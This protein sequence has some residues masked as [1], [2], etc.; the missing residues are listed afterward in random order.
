MDAHSAQPVTTT[1]RPGTSPATV[2]RR[3]T[4]RLRRAAGLLAAAIAL[5]AVGVTGPSAFAMIIPASPG[6]RPGRAPPPSSG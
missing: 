3:A 6:G 2:T 5:L 4:T 1:S